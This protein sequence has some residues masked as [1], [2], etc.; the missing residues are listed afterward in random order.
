MLTLSHATALLIGA[1]MAVW[2]GLAVWAVW[3][4][5]KLRSRAAFS[6]SQAD[7]LAALLDSAPA[8]PL[9]VRN[10]GRIEA[11]ERL[12]DWLGLARV[13]NFL[14]DLAGNN[15]G[16]SSEDAAALGRDAS[17]VQKTGRSFAR[18]VRPVGSAR[19][20]LIK[21]APAST[22]LASSGAV[23]LWW[24]DATESQ[25]EI[26]RLGEEAA[27]LTLAFDRLSGLIEAAPMPMWHRSPDLKLALVNAAY[28]RAVEAPSGAD[29]I[30]R[31][32]ELVDAGNG[33]S[34]LKSAM[35][36]SEK[37]QPVSRIVPVTLA[38]ERRSMRIVDV[39]LGEAGVAGYALDVD[40]VERANTAFRRFAATQRDTL[41]R[42]SAGV[43]QFSADRTLVFCNQPF[44]RLFALKPE[45][46]TD[47]PEFD[48]LLDRMREA[49]RIPETRDFPGWRAERRE[50]FQA[51]GGAF[52]ESWILG[53]GQHLRVVVQPLPDGGLLL[54]FEDRTEQAQLA[55]ARDT[56][57]RV[58]TATFDNLFE[59]VAVFEANGRLHL[60][61][62]RFRDVW[63]FE[64]DFLAT[65]PH[66]DALAEAAASRLSSGGRANVIREMVRSATQERAQRSGRLAMK[67]G[68]HFEFAAVPLPD[69][70][71]LFALLD[72][73]D[74]RKVERA[75][76]E[77]TT[78]LEEAD[79]VKTAFVANMSYELR[80]PL[81]SI[82]GFAEMLQQGFGGALEP[83]GKDY[84]DAILESTA[85]L[86][87]LVDR[88]LD[89]TQSD[90]GQLPLERKHVELALVL[91][92]AVQAHKAQ[93]EAK[94]IDFAIEIDPMVGAIGGDARRLRQAFDALLENALGYT[95]AGGR[96]LLH[97]GGDAREAQIVVSDNGPGMD[98]AAQTA[99]LDRFSRAT[100]PRDGDTALGLGLPLARQ[101]VEAHGGTLTLMSEPGQGTA[102][103]V[104][105]PR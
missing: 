68:Q 98:A 26:G 38:G 2:L 105:L 22:G 33:D 21:G 44:Q 24:F 28:V 39:P 103:Q 27:R 42:L 37:G 64:E 18:A 84:V 63:G 77:R 5:L 88:V 17:A 11:P 61:N 66:V 20:L 32:L 56:L 92:D 1:V 48:R 96:V 36:A 83:S 40:D 90:A 81:T 75:L 57:L 91:H 54:V 49:G 73:S 30:S 13:P 94:Q 25:A 99:A 79:K 34:P 53:G 78:A 97:A 19:T 82:S 65:H 15:S 74:S 85:R 43:A 104:A 52:E 12:A 62:N 3:T 4:G 95:P 6:T 93:A 69:G 8:L 41:D 14:T 86:G 59:A 7:R 29:V 89:L 67:N 80:T 55:S 9:M 71:A 16:L 10:D 87:S 76:R 58:R 47:H 50:W 45:W 23:I 101:F 102:V 60:W 35:Q 51:T 70:N 100:A 72:I 31:G 46:V